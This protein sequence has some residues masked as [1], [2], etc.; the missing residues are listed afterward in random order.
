M[1]DELIVLLAVIC[2]GMAGL[3]LGWCARDCCGWGRR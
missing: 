2:A 1:S 3:G